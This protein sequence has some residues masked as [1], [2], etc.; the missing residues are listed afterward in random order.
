VQGA[1]PSAQQD[2]PGD[3]LARRAGFDV[4]REDPVEEQHAEPSH[5]EGLDQ[6][7]DCQ[8]DDHALRA[9][10]NPRKAGE[11]HRHHHR[12]DHRPDQHG[13]HEVDRAVF[14]PGEE[15]DQPGR[16]LAEREARQDRQRD[17]EREVS[18]E[19]GHRL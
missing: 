12:V 18:F 8:R 11:V 15:P 4:R 7:V 3:V 1:A 16:D 10:M 19:C 5:G 14:Q 6:P 13:D 9:F 2:H 17:P